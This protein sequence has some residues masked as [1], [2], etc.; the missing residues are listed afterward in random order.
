MRQLFFALALALTAC[1]TPA[2]HADTLSA[3]PQIL[4][5]CALDAGKDRE[6]LEECVGLITRH[7]VAEEGGSNAMTDVLCRSG[8]ADAWQA[9]IDENAARI[10]AADPVD[11][12]LLAAANQA[13]TLWREAECEYRAYEYGGGSGEQYDR[14]VCQL[15]LTATRAID[16]ITAD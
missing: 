16:L 15:R 5:A 4:R 2:A 9:L 10:A 11:G 1:A 6:A 7:C 3:D 8:E 12:E 13:W 14:I